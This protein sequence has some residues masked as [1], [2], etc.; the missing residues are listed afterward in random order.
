MTDEMPVTGTDIWYYMICKRE[1]WLMSH[2]ITPD[3]E[4]ENIEIGRFMQE[5]MMQKSGRQE[6][7]TGNA[8]MD[9]LKKVDGEYVV[10]EI[11]KSSR[12]KESSRMQLLYYLDILREIGIE[13]R[14]QLVFPKE[15]KRETLEW[16]PE[17]KEELD[18]VIR[19]IRRIARLPVPPRPEKI[20]FCWKCA[21]REY[22]WAGEE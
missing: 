9:R 21:Y 15:R 18:E 8:T 4:D 14:G 12:Y 5:Y 7:E 16:T 13:A 22:C 17:R 1:S 20:K 10:E 6:V 19:D 3:E 11:K 2:E